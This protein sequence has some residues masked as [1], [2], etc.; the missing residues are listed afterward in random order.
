M[1][2]HPY[3]IYMR[4]L[5]QYIIP[6]MHQLQLQLQLGHLADALIQSDLHRLIHTLTHR[7]CKATASSSG[8]VRV[9]CLAQG[10]INTQLGGAGDPWASLRPF[11]MT[12]LRHVVTTSSYNV[13][14]SLGPYYGR[15]LNHFVRS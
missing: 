6:S 13:I 4:S 2:L 11:I 10:L 5:N 14:M 9:E 1:S 7:P 15:S 8:A 3:A 12:S